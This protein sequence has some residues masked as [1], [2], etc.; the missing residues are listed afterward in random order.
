M[1][2]AAWLTAISA[3][4]AA[5]E[6]SKCPGCRG[7][8]CPILSVI[9]LWNATVAEDLPAQLARR[10]SASNLCIAFSR[11]DQQRG[12]FTE[13]L[14]GGWVK[15]HGKAA[16]VQ[17]QPHLTLS[18]WLQ[19]STRL[20]KLQCPGGQCFS[21]CGP[22]E[23][24]TTNDNENLDALNSSFLPV[25]HRCLPSA[26]CESSCRH[27]RHRSRSSLLLPCEASNPAQSSQVYTSAEGLRAL[28]RALP[29]RPLDTPPSPD[30]KGTSVVHL[31]EPGIPCSP[32]ASSV[33]DEII[34]WSCL[35][36]Y[37]DNHILRNFLTP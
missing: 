11:I 5:K 2:R 27:R 10:S 21:G 17:I 15:A 23:N 35:N 33:H 26:S 37:V 19:S 31:L 22:R 24:P 20:P 30:T 34:Y 12:H 7:P 14:Y 9:G 18:D 28:A 16:L 4:D 36:P 32:D 6:H 8:F 13:E 1:T 29:A 3:N 25:A